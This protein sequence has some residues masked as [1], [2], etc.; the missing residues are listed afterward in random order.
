MQAAPG[1]LI[2]SWYS[3]SLDRKTS[4]PGQ[5]RTAFSIVELLIVLVLISILAKMAITSAAAST[6]DQLRSTAGIV[7]SEL[8]YARSL[9][10]ANNSSYRFDVDVPG[11]RLVLRHVGADAG[12]NT[13]PLSPYRSATDPSDQHIVRL[14]DFT[15]LGMLVRVMGAQ[16]VGTTTTSVSSIE[17]GPYGATAQT[18][19]SVLWLT[20]GLSSN[21]RFISV[22]VNPVTGLA[23]VGAYTGVAPSGI[24]IPTS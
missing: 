15:G 8:N 9:A 18:N 23:T 20:A 10:V 12:L 11:N 13:M 1:T 16:A 14:A 2:T 6:Y 3:G 5:T 17:F 7:A 22:T 21:R 24:T 4:R 19:T